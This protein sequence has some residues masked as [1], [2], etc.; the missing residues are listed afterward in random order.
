MI[1]ICLRRSTV[2]RFTQTPVKYAFS[3]NLRIV[4]YEGVVIK[5]EKLSFK[6]YS[7]IFTKAV[8]KQTFM[9]DHTNIYLQREYLCFHG[10]RL[11]FIEDFLI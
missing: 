5:L 10:S 1:I 4:H 3:E 9:A 11:H 6:E 8:K 2:E 7:A